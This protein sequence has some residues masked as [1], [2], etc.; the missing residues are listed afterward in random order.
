[1][2]IRDRGTDPEILEQELK[3]ESRYFPTAPV[4][5]VRLNWA[6]QETEDKLDALVKGKKAIRLSDG[7]Y[8]HKDYWLSLIH[9]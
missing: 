8:I 7:S 5:A 6:N 2:C 9:I 4:M 3:E 1:M